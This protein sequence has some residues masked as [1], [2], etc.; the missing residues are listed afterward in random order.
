MGNLPF[1]GVFLEER[2]C[3][4]SDYVF[5]VESIIK[6]LDLGIFLKSSQVLSQFIFECPYFVGSFSPVE[7]KI[8]PHAR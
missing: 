2:D 7:K 4:R 1:L 3:K 6:L 5:L 8:N